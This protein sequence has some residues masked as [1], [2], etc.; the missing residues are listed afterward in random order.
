M[1]WASAKGHTNLLPLL[2]SRGSL[3]Y[4]GTFELPAV[5]A[6]RSS[7]TNSLD[8]SGAESAVTSSASS[9]AAA[10]AAAT[11]NH[12]SNRRPSLYQAPPMVVHPH[13]DDGDGHPEGRPLLPSDDP[14]LVS[15]WEKLAFFGRRSSAS[16]KP[17]HV[18]GHLCKQGGIVK[19]WKVRYF[20]LSDTRLSYFSKQVRVG[21]RPRPDVHNVC[22]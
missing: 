14:S 11:T 15:P 1:D 21:Y 2:N 9:F 13:P 17:R 12:M 7:D 5:A 19:S 6:F 16:F 20:V 10:A 8:D 22:V 4:S 3:R 18:E